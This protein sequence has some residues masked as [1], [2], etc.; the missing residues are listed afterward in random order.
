MTAK[1]N[2]LPLLAKEELSGHMLSTQATIA[3]IYNDEQY[4][5]F[6]PS[7]STLSANITVLNLKD[8]ERPNRITRS[9]GVKCLNG[10]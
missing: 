2:L 10:L 5:E 9:I 6:R 8:M 1:L 3:Q 7:Y 4:F